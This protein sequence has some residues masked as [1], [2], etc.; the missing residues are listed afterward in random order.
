MREHGD[1]AEDTQTPFIDSS[2]NGDNSDNTASTDTGTNS[3]TP[4]VYAKWPQ[5]EPLMKK[6]HRILSDHLKFV[7]AGIIA[8]VSYIDPGNWSVDFVSSSSANSNTI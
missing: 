7:G 4:F 2:Y 6:L 3:S 5:P 8:A 1:D